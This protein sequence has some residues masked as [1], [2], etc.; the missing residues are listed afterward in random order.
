MPT[1]TIYIHAELAGL[2][3]GLITFVII[4]TIIELIP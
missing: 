2:L 4:K 3:V 1:I